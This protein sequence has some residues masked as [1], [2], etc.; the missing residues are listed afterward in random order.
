MTLWTKCIVHVYKVYIPPRVADYHV[1]TVLKMYNTSYYS[2]AQYTYTGILNFEVRVA[3]Q[4]RKEF[5]EVFV[6]SVKELRFP[7][8]VFTITNYYN[9][10]LNVK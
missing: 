10:K 5:L 7:D 8:N 3:M 4:Y 6:T 9:D 2:T 1:E